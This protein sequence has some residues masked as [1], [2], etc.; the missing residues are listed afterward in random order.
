MPSHPCGVKD[1]SSMTPSVQTSIHHLKPVSTNASSFVRLD[2][3]PVLQICFVSFLCFF[4]NAK[5]KK[6]GGIR[7][8][9]NNEYFQVMF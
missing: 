8:Q 1:D 9:I 3:I 4:E 7:N 5:K 2:F 6:M